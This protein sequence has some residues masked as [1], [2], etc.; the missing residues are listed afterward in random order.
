MGFKRPVT[1][2]KLLFEGTEYDGLEITTSSLSVAE[3]Q[4]VTRS[5]A[6]AVEGDVSTA[7]GMVKAS[8]ELLR[9]FADSIVTWNLEEEDDTPILPSFEAVAS[10]EPAFLMTIVSAWMGAITGVSPDLGKDSGSGETFPE[11]LIPMVS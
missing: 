11:A 2:Y 5:S 8:D 10:L 1:N 9:K 3:L 6:S 4:E 7:L